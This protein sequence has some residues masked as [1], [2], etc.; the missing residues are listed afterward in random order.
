MNIFSKIERVRPYPLGTSGP[1]RSVPEHNNE[2]IWNLHRNYVT[3]TPLAKRPI[4]D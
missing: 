4:L 2:Q 3:N 1:C